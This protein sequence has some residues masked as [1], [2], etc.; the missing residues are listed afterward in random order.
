MVAM[1][2]RIA[3]NSGRRFCTALVL[4]W[5]AAAT[6]PIDRVAA[7]PARPLLLEGKQALYQRVIAVPGA[8]IVDA[9]GAESDRAR[10]VTPFTVFYV[11]ARQ[12][13]GGRPWL[14][15]G[16]DSDGKTEGWL[17][18]EQAVDWRQTLT[19]GF[20]DPAKQAR[21]RREFDLFRLKWARELAA[22]DPYYNPH[23]RLDRCDYA[24]RA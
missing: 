24:L 8:T 2:R 3:R 20:K 18:A 6:G 12:E 4:G 23:F 17:P 7:Q 14:E 13:V 19:V 16:R 1:I 11:Y 9:A 22:G 21:F 15:V 5:V 10:P